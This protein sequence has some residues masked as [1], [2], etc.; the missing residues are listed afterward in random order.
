MTIPHLQQSWRKNLKLIKEFLKD[1]N[2]SKYQLAKKASEKGPISMRQVFKI[3]SGTVKNPGS[4]TILFIIWALQDF[5]KSK[6]K[7]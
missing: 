2:I 5:E 1:N 6:T 3:L 4:N 7:K